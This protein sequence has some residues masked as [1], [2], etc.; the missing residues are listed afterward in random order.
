MDIDY[1]A[2]GKRVKKARAKKNISQEKL[3]ELVDLTVPYISNI[4]NGNTKLGLQAILSIANALDVTADDLLC[5]NMVR[6]K[7]VFVGEIR[8][9][10]DD[11][12]DYETKV[13]VKVMKAAK[14]AIRENEKFI[15][16]D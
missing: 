10:V 3:A 4:E 16:Q 14:E 7:T 11:S 5:D 1:S 12:T 8:E 9:I 6:S 2:I 13:M 15:K